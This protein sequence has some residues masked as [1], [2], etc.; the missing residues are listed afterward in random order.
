MKPIQKT[1]H[2][3]HADVKSSEQWYVLDADGKVLG[4]V[5]TKLATMIRGKHKPNWHPSVNSG[6]HVIVINAEKVVLTGNK[7][8]TKEYIHHTQFPGGIKRVQAG[9]M[10]IKK[11][12]H[13]IETAV[14]G[15]IPRNRIRQFALAKLHVYKGAEHPHAGQNPKTLTF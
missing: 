15:M 12:E 8:M 11:P 10:R 6:D 5:A 2:P 14:K 9:K 7:E 1:T 13:M 4:Q 3:K